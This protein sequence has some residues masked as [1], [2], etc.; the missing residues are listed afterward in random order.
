MS[1]L[2]DINTSREAYRRLKKTG[3]LSSKALRM[4][5]PLKGRKNLMKQPIL[6]KLS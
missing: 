4:L 6:L 3:K 1:F 2:D 5:M